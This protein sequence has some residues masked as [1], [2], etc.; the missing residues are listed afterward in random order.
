MYT[1]Q[2]V[3]AAKATRDAITKEN[4]SDLKSIYMAGEIV[5]WNELNSK[6]SQ[7]ASPVSDAIGFA[8]TVELTKEIAVD[9]F[10]ECVFDV[11]KDTYTNLRK[12]Y[13][14]WLRTSKYHS[15]KLSSP[16]P[17][18]ESKGVEQ[19]KSFFMPPDHGDICWHVGANSFSRKEVEMMLYTQRA[20]ISNDLKQMCGDVI[21]DTMY[22]VLE[23]P[24]I[25]EY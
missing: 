23:Q 4:I 7:Q 9:F 2:E 18:T 13:D 25:P 16:T 21:T 10:W 11:Q 22:E 15:N 20:M 12:M 6:K 17:H 1:Q 8:E 3:A 5:M 24:R 14:D 19:E